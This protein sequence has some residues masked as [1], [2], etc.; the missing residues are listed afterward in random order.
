M[1]KS[2]TF[3]KAPDK[4]NT[5]KAVGLNIPDISVE[6]MMG[7]FCRVPCGKTIK[8]DDQLVK[9]NSELQ[10]NEYIVFDQDRIRIKYIVHCEKSDS[11]PMPLTNVPKVAVNPPK[12]KQSV[13]AQTN[14][15]AVKPK[16]KS[17]AAKTRAT[18]TTPTTVSP[19][20]STVPAIPVQMPSARVSTSTKTVTN[21]PIKKSG[22]GLNNSAT[23][24]SVKPYPGVKTLSLNTST[25]SNMTFVITTPSI[26]QN[27][28]I[29]SSSTT[30]SPAMST[31]P[32]ISTQTASAR[33]NTSST[34]AVKNFPIN[35][36][37]ASLNNKSVVMTRVGQS[38]KPKGTPTIP[39]TFSTNTSSAYGLTQ[40]QVA[41]TK[42]PYSSVK[43]KPIV[44]V[45]P[46]S[47][48]VSPSSVKSRPGVNKSTPNTIYSTVTPVVT[49]PSIIQN[50]GISS[51]VNAASS[52]R[53]SSVP[54]SVKPNAGLTQN[55][56]ATRIALTIPTTLHTN[57]SAAYGT[58]VKQNAVLS[59][60]T[61]MKQHSGLTPS[62]NAGISGLVSTNSDTLNRGVT[63]SSLKTSSTKTSPFTYEIVR[64]EPWIRKR[65]PS[66]VSK[67]SSNSLRA[68][69]TPDE[70]IND[71]T[72][73]SKVSTSPSIRVSANLSPRYATPNVAY[74]SDNTSST[75]SSRTVSPLVTPG[76]GIFQ[77]TPYTVN[78]QGT[79][80]RRR[81]S[82]YYANKYNCCVIL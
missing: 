52:D 78:Y 80:D 4:F 1:C 29:S 13:T 42:I 28:G 37:S 6:K 36:S 63:P 49:T 17:S 7:K 3:Y 76:P 21:M 24:S 20:M 30:I 5:L 65:T 23:S 41:A 57:P 22:A 15:T 11:I 53:S 18:I 70:I 66:C 26:R 67:T 19:A 51:G 27:H 58:A 81:K 40:T 55:T 25:Y 68:D 73:P 50:Q 46:V 38:L 44:G 45:T 39:S 54:T 60:L 59:S 33:V 69:P 8:H 34:K 2:E 61:N 71:N 64:Q 31:T 43:V 48:D 12:A 72:M 82:R 62:T 16:A 32:T 77:S 10:Y 74:V 79:T 14:T 75:T 9:D 35:K 56:N 47:S